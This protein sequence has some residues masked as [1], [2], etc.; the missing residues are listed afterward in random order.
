MRSL[1]CHHRLP[2][3]IL[4]FLSCSVCCVLW[5]SFPSVLSVCLSHY[6]SRLFSTPST[7]VIVVVLPPLQ[8]HSCRPSLPI[9]SPF[10]HFSLIAPLCLCRV[11]K[12]PPTGNSLGYQ[13]L[14]GLLLVALSCLARCLLLP[15]GDI[16][17]STDLL[18]SLTGCDTSSSLLFSLSFTL[19]SFRSAS[20]SPSLGCRWPFF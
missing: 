20:G 5:V 17:A 15:K 6:S 2:G 16:L 8:S 19:Q 11:N 4:L 18:L 10:S 12:R 13:C 3:P 14:G 7:T 9:L 1:A